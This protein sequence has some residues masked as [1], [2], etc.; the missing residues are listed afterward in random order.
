MLFFITERILSAI[1]CLFWNTGSALKGAMSAQL[2]SATVETLLTSI[3]SA[4]YALVGFTSAL[5]TALIWV[6][7]L[8]LMGSI[9]YVTYE[10]APWVWTDLARAYNAFMGPF[11]DST[12][13]QGFKFFD[14]VF[15]GVIPLYNASIF[16]ISRIVQGFIFPTL[17]TEILA[18]QQVGI[19]LYDLCRHLIVSLFDWLSTVVV[20]CPD[21]NGDACFDLTDRTLDLVTPMADVRNTIVG[22]FGIAESVCSPFRPVSNI[23][24]YPLLDLNLAKGLHNLL[25]AVL[26]L[27]VQVPEVTYIRCKRHGSAGYLMCT[28]DLEPV[29]AFLVQGLRDIGIML[30]NW[31]EVI[32]VVVQG[33][34]GVSTSSCEGVQLVPPVLSPGPL[35]SSLFPNRTVIVDSQIPSSG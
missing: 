14:I 13:V 5:T 9:F 18:V 17:S 12:L 30:D 11:I 33:V 16:L 1:L 27:V 19:S 2:L 7:F 32:F 6:S 35:R 4:A 15:K 24:V 8:L 3:T 25:N 22:L 23:L 28:P 29:F 21:A 20:N 10:Q 26:Y 34:F 31:L